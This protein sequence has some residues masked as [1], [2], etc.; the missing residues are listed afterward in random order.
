M[1]AEDKKPRVIKPSE[2]KVRRKRALLYGSGIVLAII[3]IVV[4]GLFIHKEV[5]KHNST[6]LVSTV[7]HLENTGVCS[8]GLKQLSSTEPALANSTQYND[9]AREAALNYLISCYFEAGNTTKSLAYAAQL[10]TLYAQDGNKT[11]QR[12]QLAQ[13]VTYIKNYGH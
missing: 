11:Q 2:I 3:I 4:L 5:K 10:D 1:E 7:S 9:A 12:A 6:N 8:S 13:Y